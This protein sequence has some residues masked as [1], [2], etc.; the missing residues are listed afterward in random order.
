MK[1]NV[2]AVVGSPLR[3]WA[4]NQSPLYLMLLP[5]VV[6]LF[7]FS[8]WPMFGLIMAFTDFQP[9]K[10]FLGSPFVG[11]KWFE[12]LFYNSP[13][14]SQVLLNTVVIALLK[15]AVGTFASIV[16]ALLL[17]EV[18][19]RWFK[20]TVQTI[21][22]L[23]N[24]LSWVVI[25]GMVVDLL[26]QQGIV[27]R[28][29][30]AFGFDDIPFL[31]SNH[32]FRTVIVASDVWKNFGFGAVLYL[33]AIAGINPEL[34]EACVVDGGGKWRR[35]RHITLPGI[36]P[37]LIMLSTLNLGNILNAGQDQILILYNPLVYETGDIL[38]TFAYRSG[39]VNVQYSFA[40]AV[41]FFKSL[42]GL[43]FILMANRLSIRFASRRIF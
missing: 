1:T 18:V 4:K 14:F 12:Y 10:G 36:V 31:Q 20:K 40:T 24:F 17:N 34:Y 7:L 3:R 5:G 8:Y 13:D 43:A 23:P 15:I 21:T 27:N 11:L 35:M 32:W 25:G 42:V 41:G 26:S 9:K 19:G 16:F 2:L 22:Y 38:D 28:I 37:T 33:A 6:L 29:I 39:I 30:H